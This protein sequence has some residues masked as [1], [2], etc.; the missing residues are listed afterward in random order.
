MY[1]VEIWPI[2]SIIQAGMVI[3]SRL[4]LFFDPLPLIVAYFSDN[5]KPSVPLEV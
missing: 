1:G 4:F 3:I 5:K 2:A